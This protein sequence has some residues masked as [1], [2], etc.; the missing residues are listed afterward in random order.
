VRGVHA[1][2]QPRREGRSRVQESKAVQTGVSVGIQVNG[3]QWALSSDIPSHGT[4]YGAIGAQASRWPETLLLDKKAGPNAPNS[5]AVF[6]LC[7]SIAPIEGLFGDVSRL[8]LVSSRFI[9]RNDSTKL[10][11]ELKQTEAPDSTSIQIRPGERVPFHWS[12]CHCPRLIS[13]RPFLGDDQYPYNWSGGF[14]P[15]TI[16]AI[17]LRI[18]RAKGFEATLD[19]CPI[20]QSIKMETEIRPKTGGA[21]INLLFEEEDR[22]GDGTLFRIENWSPYTVWLSQDDIL[23]NPPSGL[24]GSTVLEGFAVRPSQTSCFGLDVPFRQ[25]KHSLRQSATM[26]ELLQLRIGLA[27]LESRAGVETTKT[28]SLA[29]IGSRIRLNPSKLVFLDSKMRSSLRRVRVLGIVSNDG[30]TT[31]LSFRYVLFCWI[32]PTPVGI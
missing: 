29:K 19:K 15:L 27:P 20:V 26:A 4:V 8:M 21:G 14:D 18:R 3:G 25:G 12:E 31:V 5:T 2:F 9:A 11:F 17:P 10:T 24:V 30:P 16:G 1:Y 13:V 22:T 6:E 23:S 32:E 28:I 7:Y